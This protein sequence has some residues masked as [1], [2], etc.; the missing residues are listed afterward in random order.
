MSEVTKNIE[1]ARAWAIYGFILDYGELRENATHAWQKALNLDIYIGER[2][3]FGI[4][5]VNDNSKHHYQNPQIREYNVKSELI[6]TMD[7]LT[8]IEFSRVSISNY[9]FIQ[10][11]SQDFFI[12]HQYILLKDIIPPF[13]HG[14]ILY[15]Y[16]Y[17]INTKTLSIMKLPTRYTDYN[18]RAGRIL[19]YQIVDLARRVLSHN[20]HPTYSF[21][22]AF[23]GS[24]DLGP[25]T[26]RVQCE[27]TIVLTLHNTP[28]DTTPWV[29]SIG[30]KPRFIRDK[31]FR[32]TS[33]EDMPPE[34]EIFDAV[35]NPRD[36]L[37]YMGRHLVHFHRTTLKRSETL[38]QI[39]L[40]FVQED[41]NDVYD[42]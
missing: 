34:D 27:F 20:V 18:S 13:V 40:H 42:I 36:A 37:L 2:K 11:Q 7:I 38:L 12:K 39:L 28:V 32:G 8:Y 16:E 25:H 3:Y 14:A 26:D 24:T 5:I 30:T 33:D 1:E 22:S 21:F 41:F 17:L 4:M 29:M 23:V 35:M 19:H 9:P 6:M 31:N 10:P 15:N